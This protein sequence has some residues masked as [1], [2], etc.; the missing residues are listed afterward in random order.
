MP[1]TQRS[2]QA[3]KNLV[4]NHIGKS[5]TGKNI[6]QNAVHLRVDPQPRDM[7]ETRAMLRVLKEFG[8]I[9]SFKHAK[10][11][12]GT[13][14]GAVGNQ[15]NIA[16]NVFCVIFRTREAANAIL[17]ASP[18]KFSL[19]LARES[20]DEYDDE[21]QENTDS[22]RAD[23]TTTKE[24]HTDPSLPLSDQQLNAN[25]RAEA[26]A[27]TASES[28]QTKA[29]QPENSENRP[30]IV[31]RNFRIVADIWQGNILDHI[32]R[33]PFYHG[34]TIDRKTLAQ[35]DLELKVPSYAL[36]DVN[37]RR[38]SLSLDGVKMETKRIRWRSPLRL[39]LLEALEARLRREE[40]GQVDVSHIE[41][42]RLRRREAIE[43]RERRERERRGK[44]TAQGRGYR[45]EESHGS[46]S[47]ST[48]DAD[49]KSPAQRKRERKEREDRRRAEASEEAKRAM[50]A[51]NEDRRFT[52]VGNILKGLELKEKGTR[53]HNWKEG[54]SIGEFGAGV[55]QSDS[56]TD[57]WGTWG[58]A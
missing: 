24:D 36:S 1:L 25:L 3:V 44:F 26:A 21:Q 13:A 28:S 57:D 6:V 52:P 38:R 35:R 42:I 33:G 49:E 23:N 39:T 34:F 5:L 9:V 46:R 22:E 11:S 12:Y 7:G 15:L 30:E 55:E 40:G 37:L 19:E 29:T 53:T 14:T 4:Y 58:R 45:E 8:E 2:S 41:E 17:K 31:T 20:D 47:A 51:Y 27:T 10:H 50:K 56:D 54:F 43:R 48:V 16:V 32:A 18:L